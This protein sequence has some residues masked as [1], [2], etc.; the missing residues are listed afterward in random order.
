MRTRAR[1]TRIRAARKDKGRDVGRNKREK[2]HVVDAKSVWTCVTNDGRK[3][4]RL[5]KIA[6]NPKR[7]DEVLNRYL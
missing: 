5:K 7:L 3:I 6:P 2:M 4:V 1:H